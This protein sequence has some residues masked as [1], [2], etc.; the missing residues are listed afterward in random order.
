MLH[1]ISSSTYS[2]SNAGAKGNMHLYTNPTRHMLFA[3]A[4]SPPPQA[5]MAPIKTTCICTPI[6]QDLCCLPMQQQAP[7]L[8][9]PP[10]LPPICIC[11]PI[12][13]DPCCLPPPPPPPPPP[14]MAPVPPPMAIQSVTIQC[15][16]IC[17]PPPLP[18]P[19]PPMRQ[20]PIV[21]QCQP[22]LCQQLQCQP[23]CQC[24]PGYVPCAQKCCLRYRKVNN[25]NNHFSPLRNDNN[26]ILKFGTS[27][28]NP[29]E[30]SNSNAGQLLPINQAAATN[31]HLV[32]QA[33]STQEK[34]VVPSV[35]S[36]LF[37]APIS[38]RT[39]ADKKLTEKHRK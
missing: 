39:V 10:P 25:N 18:P 30:N 21:M 22:M 16:P 34:R 4:S 26:K 14:Q 5:Q 12:Q 6:Q 36:S 37:P 32:P 19:P 2:A 3:T 9:P 13:Q 23:I 7:P 24:Q 8:P 1:S 17:V 27:G 33:F 29:T 31:P 28:N 35:P 11:S 38:K 15:A 20:P